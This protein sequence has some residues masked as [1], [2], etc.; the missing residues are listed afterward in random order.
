MKMPSGPA[1]TVQ[2]RG[3][4]ASATRLHLMLGTSRVLHRQG[5]V[6]GLLDSDCP[7]LPAASNC[8]HSKHGGC[9]TSNDDQRRQEA[10]QVQYVPPWWASYKLAASPH[11]SMIHAAPISGCEQLCR[12]NHACWKKP[13]TPM[14]TYM[15]LC[16]KTIRRGMAAAG[17]PPGTPL[18][19]P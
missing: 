9:R 3:C 2:P 8:I 18:D 11:E 5:M 12:S 4:Q 7:Q 17:Q 14:R 1:R 15:H 10:S 6:L 16:G 19:P 13:D